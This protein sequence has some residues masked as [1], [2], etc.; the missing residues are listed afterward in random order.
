MR[1]S[2]TRLTRRSTDRMARM[3]EAAWHEMMRGVVAECRRVLKPS[4]SAVFVL[5]PNSERV[6][7]DRYG[8]EFMVWRTEMESSPGCLVVE[9]LL[10]AYRSLQ[11]A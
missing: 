1:L 2:P 6:G 5:Q 11:P 7:R 4:G 8:L 9:S 10:A 3:T